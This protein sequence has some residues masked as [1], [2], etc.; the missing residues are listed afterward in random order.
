M[1][2]VTVAKN[3]LFKE[4]D[5]DLSEN[6]F[7]DLCFEFGLELDDVTT[8]KN[9]NGDLEVFYKIEVAA[10]RYD[11]LC[12]EGLSQAL[13]IFL[14]KQVQPVY[15]LTPADP[16]NT[17][18]VDESVHGIRPFVVSAIL[19]NLSF[20]KKS[21]KSFI[22]LQEK[23][24]QN[25]C[26]KRVLVAIGTHDL[27]SL[28]APFVYTSKAPE[29]I[30][31]K[32]LYQEQTLTAVELMNIYRNDI[33]MKNYVPIIENFDRYPVIYDSNGVILS[34]P[35][36]INGDHSKIHLNTKNVL[37]ECT[38]T[39]KN[40]ALIVLNTIIAG[41][42]KYCESSYT[43]EAVVIK[44]SDTQETTPFFSDRN[45]AVDP[46][47]VNSLIGISLSAEKMSELLR[48]MGV[49]SEVL[50]EKLNVKV[51]INRSDIIHPCDIAEDIGIAYGYNN[52]QRVLPH[53]LTVGKEQP[54]NHITDLLRIETGL[55]GYTEILTFALHSYNF[56]YHLLRRPLDGLDVE[57]SNQKALEFQ[58]PR[59]T[60]LSGILRTIA[61]NTK[62]HLPLKIF[63]ISD[64]VLK[65]ETAEV[66][67][68]N[69]RH[70]AAGFCG[71]SAGLENIHGLLDT[72]MRKLGLKWNEDYNLSSADDPAFFP[73]RQAFVNVQGVKVG[74]FG[75][76]H[77]EV[78]E[79]F[80]ITFPVSAIEL[81]I[82]LITSLS[83]V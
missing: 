48:K 76:V 61:T 24:H 73:K 6:E 30:Q 34:M 10:N 4:L 32:A 69:Q 18:T 53:T 63:E 67:A 14:G 72:I 65:D 26:R 29:E 1:P 64:V 71:H 49:I 50:N 36:I 62:L 8:E 35:P 66:K 45:L 11:L 70:L 13:K 39:D 16:Q 59:T 31:F 37:I 38:G 5:I 54:L 56:N 57:I 52:I 20:T 74:I 12:I 7:R 25:I 21:L 43:A 41:F 3:D 81:D 58:L 9:E 27:D 42:S 23:L 83:R 2:K 55:A 77:P 28:K 22:E 75:I 68:K 78:L 40:K 17:I 79:N 19:R 80:S 44:Y 33:R 46:K 82:E 47:Y 60:L 15:S 51:P